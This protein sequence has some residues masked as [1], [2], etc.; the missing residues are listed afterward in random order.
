MEE[1]IVRSAATVRFNT[2]LLSGLGLVG[3]A[4]AVIG[5]Y[6]VVSGYVAERR[7]EIGVRM[8]LG[9]T[10]RGVVALVVRRAAG[11]VVAGLAA[12]LAAAWA[13][14]RLLGSQLFGVEP[15]DPVAFTGAGAVLLAAALAASWLPSRRAARVDPTATLREGAA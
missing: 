10:P 5:L 14:T 12:G 2:L 1:R 3:L 13:L 11:P 6:G 15:T 8:A 9:S 7:D 4:L